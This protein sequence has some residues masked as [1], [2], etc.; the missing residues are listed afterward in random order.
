MAIAVKRKVRTK[1]PDRVYR[2]TEGELFRYMMYK[3]KIADFERGIFYPPDQLKDEAYYSTVRFSEERVMG[4]RL[5]QRDPIGN[6]VVKLLMPTSRVYHLKA[7]VTTIEE[8]VRSLSNEHRKVF[9]H[10][11]CENDSKEITCMETAISLATFYR[12]KDEIVA[13][14]ALNMGWW[15]EEPA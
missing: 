1:P 15:H 2:F 14:V 3:R 5:V 12:K 11:Y 8:T 7:V 9:W 10:Y 13:G 4:G 6:V